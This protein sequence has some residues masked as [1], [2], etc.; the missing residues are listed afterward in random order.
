MTYKI[1]IQPSAHQL[2]V[3]D[4]ETILDAALRHG[5]SFPYGCRGGACGACMGKVVSGTID[6]R[7][8]R[9]RGISEQE[10]IA[11]QV[12]FCQAYPS[13]DLE[14]EV[15]EIL[16]Q[17]EIRVK[18]L[19]V[20]LAHKEKLSHDIMQLKLQL[21]QSERLQF[22]AGQYID[23]LLADGRRR[24]FSLA[25]AP[26]NDDYLE[27]HVRHVEGGEF[28][29][30]VFD[31]LQEK[32]LLRVEGPHGDFFLREESDRPMLMI[33]GGTGFAPLKGIIEHALASDHHRPMHLFCGVRA[34][35]DLYMDEMVKGWMQQHDFVQYTPVLSEPNADEAWSGAVGF[36]HQE[37]L[38]QYQ[39]LA[40]FDIYMSGPPIMVKSAR[41]AFREQGVADENMFY[42][43]FDYAADT[44][45][46]MEQNQ[47]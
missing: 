14:I 20:R 11:G 46:K 43:S 36:V 24:A 18:T 25:N 23:I 19:P 44:L 3:D 45:K 31:S 34:Q 22:L 28:T 38:K 29:D 21:P 41:D 9:P 16:A 40:D 13:S 12:L 1:V 42:D 10:E 8:D 15:H 6:Y 2:D 26:H 35:R 32:S 33:G 39:N 7:G 4:N 30:K 47:S 37:V 17:E 5:L 27:L